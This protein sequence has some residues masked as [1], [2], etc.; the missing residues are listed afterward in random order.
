MNRGLSAELAPSFMGCF[1]VL[2]LD[3]EVTVENFVAA[4]PLP[5]GRLVE[6]QGEYRMA[7]GYPCALSLEQAE[8]EKLYWDR[9]SITGIAN[10]LGALGEGLDYVVFGNNAG[11]GLPLARALPVEWRAEKSAV[12]Y[13]SSL[14]ERKAYEEEGYRTFRPR[15][16]LLPHV[17][18]LAEA[19]GR[20]LVLAFINTIQHNEENYHVPWPGR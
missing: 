3:N 20:P 12:L 5:W 7:E 9:V 2:I 4:P 13:G 1:S 10:A 16:D 15:A 6:S 19:A 14:P 17:K 11:Q 8:R 18:P